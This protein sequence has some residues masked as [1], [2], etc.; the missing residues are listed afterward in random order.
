MSNFKVIIVLFTI[1]L[2]IFSC[3]DQKQNS[4]GTQ[5]NQA[6]EKVAIST[7]DEAIVELKNGNNRFVNHQLINTNYTDQIEAS[8]ERQTPHSVILSCMDSRV[9][10]E[11]VFDQGIGNIFVTRNAGNIEDENI[12][13]SIEYAVKFAG[14]KLIVVM[15]HSR[16]GAV[17]GAINNVDA[18]NL[19]QLVEQIKVAIPQETN[20]VDLVD[21][22]ARNSVNQTIQDILKRSS[23]V[24][25]LVETNQIKIVGAFY[26]IETGVVTFID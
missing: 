1:S 20:Q 23:I 19:T 18:G 8:K 12:L 6:V 9:P 4:E 5:K 16:C 7:P 10:P 24:K 22:T 17:T 26:N 21:G 13:G 15:G 25:E 2:F 11:I 14:S 3:S